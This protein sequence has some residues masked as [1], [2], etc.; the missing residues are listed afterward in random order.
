MREALCL[1]DQEVGHRSTCSDYKLSNR[2]GEL[3][4]WL[5]LNSR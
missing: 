4:A 2:Y 3:N 5:N 1:N